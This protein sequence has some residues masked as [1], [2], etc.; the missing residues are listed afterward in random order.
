LDPVRPVGSPGIS[1]LE[2]P[3][4]TTN[5]APAA[6]TMAAELQH[7]VPLSLVDRLIPRSVRPAWWRF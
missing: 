1:T 3:A 7:T 6:R 4:P 5:L 2:R